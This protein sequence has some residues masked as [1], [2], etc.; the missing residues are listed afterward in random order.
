MENLQIESQEAPEG[1]SPEN[2]KVPLTSTATNA[3]NSIENSNLTFRVVKPAT[4]TVKDLTLHVD[5]APNP[6]KTGVAALRRDKDADTHETAHRKTILSRIT[7]SM[8]SGTLTAIM[9]A[10]GSGKTFFF[11]Q[12]RTPRS[13]C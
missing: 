1:V 9:G 12:L 5:P 13:Q 11:P 6:L 2:D 10:S 3:N 7:A 4:I 8:P